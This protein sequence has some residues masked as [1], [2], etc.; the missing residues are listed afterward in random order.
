[1]TTD[2][3]RHHYCLT[4]KQTGRTTSSVAS[5]RTGAGVTRTL[6]ERDGGGGA[7]PE[8]KRA[9]GR[10][11]PLFGTRPPC[12]VPPPNGA[13]TANWQKPPP[14]QVSPPDPSR[15]CSGQIYARG[16]RT[17]RTD[18]T[19]AFYPRSALPLSLLLLLLR[20]DDHDVTTKTKTA[21]TRRR[22]SRVTPTGK[23]NTIRKH[24]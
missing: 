17:A 1:M 9:R 8:V 18:R 23:R 15:A 14:P 2:K 24:C 7:R 13:A 19:T 16:I 5:C 12:R 6:T 10:P 22:G 3:S 11:A 4:S 20:P 21:T